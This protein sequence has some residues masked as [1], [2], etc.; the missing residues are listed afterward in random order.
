MT[1]VTVDDPPLAPD[2]TRAKGNLEAIEDYV[3]NPAPGTYISPGGIARDNLAKLSQTV[4]Q[5]VADIVALAATSTTAINGKV[6]EITD[7]ATTSTALISGKVSGVVA[8]AGDGTDTINAQV[9][10]VQSAGAAALAAIG[11]QIDGLTSYIDGRL[12][13]SIAA[14]TAAAAALPAF[15][16][17]RDRATAAAYA[18]NGNK[19][20]LTHTVTVGVLFVMIDGRE[21][22]DA[23]WTRSGQNISTVLPGTDPVNG[24]DMTK[25]SSIAVHYR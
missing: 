19:I 12:D 17:Y 4:N 2:Y 1:T 3:N 20:T 18:S 10:A 6:A 16:Y 23:S 24:I 21:V 25:H 11:A 5:K 9:A 15:A 14:L 22:A 13:A 7:L 8:V